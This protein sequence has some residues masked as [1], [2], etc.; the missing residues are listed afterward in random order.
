MV[1]QSDCA[2]DAIMYKR[3]LSMR[4]MTLVVTLL[5]PWTSRNSSDDS[6]DSDDSDNPSRLLF[7]ASK[8][9]FN[10]V[11]IEVHLAMMNVS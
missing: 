1:T 5:V 11:N 9:N 6:D 4:N 10:L 3:V 8:M 7:C 2:A